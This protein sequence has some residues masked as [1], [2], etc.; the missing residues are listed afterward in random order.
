MFLIIRT[1]DGLSLS[2]NRIDDNGYFTMEYDE[3]RPASGMEETGA[4][5]EDKPERRGHGGLLCLLVS[6]LLIGAGAALFYRDM[7]RDLRH[8]FYRCSSG[9]MLEIPAA[10]DADQIQETA[11]GIE[12]I[13]QDHPQISQYMML[14]PS[15]GYI[16]QRF[17]PEGMAIRDQAADLASVRDDM[18]A[19]LT[20]IDLAD[21]FSGHEGEKLYYATDP[22]LTGWGSRYAARAAMKAM[23]ADMPEGR[24]ACYLLSNTFEGKLAEDDT[25]LHRFWE[26][27]AERVEIYVP[28]NEAPYYRVDAA[29]GKWSA[30][31]YDASKAEGTEPLKTFFGGERPLTEIYTAAVNGKTLLV[32][33]DSMADTI[34]P[35]FVS[36]FEKVIFVHP[37]LCGT[38]MEKLIKKYE[39]TEILYVY[40][41]NSFMTDRALLHTL[42]R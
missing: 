9:R 16:Q 28:E 4:E 40:G 31:L 29:T 8:G 2:R 22:H 23:E 37:S 42:G 41:A 11:Y 15:A 5:F 39:P 26:P 12:K 30:S 19:D 38:K 32:V 25:L 17:L 13:A 10:P 1:G 7:G 33:G 36:S 34:V 21:L 6:L 14:I 18:P 35:A 27:Q 20:W 3:L 24:D